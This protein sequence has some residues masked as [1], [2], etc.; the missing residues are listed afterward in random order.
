MAEWIKNKTYLFAACNWLISDEGH[1][2]TESE[3]M[4]KDI[5]FK[6]KP[7]KGR[8]A[9]LISDKV[10]FKTKANK[11]QKSSIFNDKGSI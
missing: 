10:D 7:N 9:I 5:S 3:G 4:E 2:Q 11:R 6:I 8:V 1:V